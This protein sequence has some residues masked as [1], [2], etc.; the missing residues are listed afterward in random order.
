MQAQNQEDKEKKW[1]YTLLV[2]D[3]M[4]DQILATSGEFSFTEAKEFEI[5]F[6]K[7]AENLPKMIVGEHYVTPPQFTSSA[8]NSSGGSKAMMK[9]NSKNSE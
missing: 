6:V 3:N 5:D 2:L 7:I 4:L 8:N 1:K 9:A